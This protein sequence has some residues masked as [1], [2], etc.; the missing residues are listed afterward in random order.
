MKNAKRNG[1]LNI[2]NSDG[3]WS[4]EIPKEGLS[5]MLFLEWV[6]DNQMRN[7]LISIT[8]DLPRNSL[9]VEMICTSEQ[10]ID[11]RT[12]IVDNM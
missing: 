9:H 2:T 11:C 7:K 1:M 10:M 12:Y 6:A 3:T 8:N 4:M 5:L